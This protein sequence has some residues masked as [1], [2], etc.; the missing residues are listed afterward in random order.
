MFHLLKSL[1]KLVWVWLSAAVLFH[2]LLPHVSHHSNE[3]DFKVVV[4]HFDNHCHA[5]YHL[6]LFK[7]NVDK[8]QQQTNKIPFGYTYAVLSRD[9]Q[10]LTKNIS[11]NLIF[12][13][14]KFSSQLCPVFMPVRGSPAV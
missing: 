8:N 3:K 14:F 13:S 2:A 9:I 12:T 1:N 6:F 7:E 10:L 4:N 11:E 5:S